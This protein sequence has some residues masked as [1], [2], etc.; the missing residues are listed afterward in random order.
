MTWF[1]GSGYGLF[2]SILIPRLEFAL[3]IVPALLIPLVILTGFFVNQSKIPFYF[4]PLEYISI[5]KWV[6]QGTAIV[7]FYA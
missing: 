6:F 5:F 3:A 4:K 1:A 7:I 2:L